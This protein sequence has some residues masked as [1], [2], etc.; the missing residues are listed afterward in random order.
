M[1]KVPVTPQVEQSRQ[2]ESAGHQ[3]G[4]GATLAAPAFQLQATAQLQTAPVQRATGTVQERFAAHTITQED[5]TDTYVVTQ[6][7]G[8][9][10]KALFEYRRLATVAAVKTHILTLIDARARDPHQSY[11]GKKFTINNASAVIKDRAGTAQTYKKGDTIPAGKKVGSQKTIPNGTVVY[12]TDI[13]ANVKL[14]H[15]EDY[16]WTSITNI[17]GG[18]FNETMTIDVAEYQSQG[19]NDKTIAT[20]DCSV[21]TNTAVTTYPE[22]KPAKTIPKNTKVTV[23]ETAAEDGGNMLVQAAGGPAVW[24]RTANLSATPNPDGTRTVI[25]TT[26]SIRRKSVDYALGTG[27]IPQGERV[28]ILQ[29]STNTETPGKYVEV[30]Y[31]KKDATGAYVRDTDRAAVW[32]AASNLADNWADFKSDNARWMK[33]DNERLNGKYLG[34]MDVVTLIGRDAS[35][36]VQEVEKLSPQLLGHY[37]T[38]RAAATVAGHDIRLNSGFRSFPEQK[39]LWDANPNPAKVA[40]PGRSNH[41]NGIAIDINTGSFETTMYAWMVANA[42]AL[43]WIRTVDGEHWHWEQR[44][45]DARQ[46]GFKLPG[47]NP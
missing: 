45:E 19:A 46:Y 31:S 27:V 28:T 38:L 11:V 26:A 34:Q 42:P 25:A 33:S 41:Q 13:T 7:T 2:L 29:R 35:S 32:I 3:E 40:R 16:G 39:E 18:M 30:A 21:R 23:L 14:V 24:T 36:G 37:N 5:L 9:T 6:F 4:Q 20:H 1:S 43:G 8:M 22:E 44:P 15:A 47:V 10:V 12:I 17:E